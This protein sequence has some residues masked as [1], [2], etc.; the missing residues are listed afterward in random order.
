[1]PMNVI[2]KSIAP[3]IKAWKGNGANISYLKKD[4][5]RIPVVFLPSKIQSNKLFLI[6]SGFHLEETSGPLF[7][8]NPKVC[9]PSF[10]D[11]LKM[12]N[13]VLF[14]LINQFGLS[15]KET[16]SDKHLR[17]NGLGLDYNSA[18]G[19]DKEKCQEVRLVEKRLIELYKEYQMVFALSLHEDSTEPGKG[20]LWMNNIRSDT[21]KTIQ[22]ALE[23]NVDKKILLQMKSTVGLRRGRIES[24]FSVVDAKDESFENFTSE[25][26]G[27]PTL[28]SEGPFGLDLNRRIAFHRAVLTSIPF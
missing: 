15:F 28:L 24:G 17:R 23:K 6:A 21:R 8:L 5:L 11:I 4:N 22:H 20:Y 7:L 19:F 10:R 12:M 25:I 3:G 16:V 18:W 2:K 9:L 27:I 1:M 26:L 14:P 13:I